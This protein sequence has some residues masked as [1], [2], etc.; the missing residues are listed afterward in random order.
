MTLTGDPTA[1]VVGSTTLTPDSPPLAL[2]GHLLALQSGG[3]LIVDSQTRRLGSSPPTTDV[4]TFTVSGVVLT[5]YLN[6]VIVVGSTTLSPGSRPF[7][8]S[9]HA[10]SL[11]TD[12]GAAVVVVDGS[13]S[14]LVPSTNGI[15]VAGA[16]SGLSDHGNNI[17]VFAGAASRHGNDANGVL[18]AVVLLLVTWELPCLVF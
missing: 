12:D 13:P 9:G 6:N 11:A 18:W 14:T 5:Q 4:Q 17:D 16:A 1:L 10:L 2:S 7:T 15:G 8:I 3:L